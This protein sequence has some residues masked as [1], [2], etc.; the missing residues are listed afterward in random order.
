MLVKVEEKY[1]FI[2]DKKTS[3]NI[4]EKVAIAE[5]KKEGI[6]MIGNLLLLVL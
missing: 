4:S 2:L 1:S 6:T 5:L 3:K